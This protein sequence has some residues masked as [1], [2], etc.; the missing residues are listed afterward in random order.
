MNNPFL[1]LPPEGPQVPGI[2]QDA[3]PFLDL[4]EEEV[5]A[6]G[7]FG[8][9]VSQPWQEKFGWNDEQR[10]FLQDLN[11]ISDEHNKYNPGTAVT[12][13]V[14]EAVGAAADIVGRLGNSGVKGISSIIASVANQFGLSETER[15][16]LERDTELIINLGLM[17]SA[18]RPGGIGRNYKGPNRKPEGPGPFQQKANQHRKT[19][20]AFDAEGI[21]PTIPALT[22]SRFVQGATNFLRDIPG[23]A[24]VLERRINKTLDQFVAAKNKAAPRI[25]K[26][27]RDSAG[28]SMRRSIDDFINVKSRD[29]MGD[30]YKGAFATLPE[31][32]NTPIPKTDKGFDLPNLRAALGNVEK[33]R[34]KAG[35][36]G[37]GVQGEVGGALDRIMASPKEKRVGNIT[38]PDALKSLSPAAKERIRKASEL[39]QEVVTTLRENP[40]IGGL[41]DLRTR[42]GQLK[43]L[44]TQAGERTL[45][46]AQVARL[47][48]ALSEDI[49]YHMRNIAG[50]NSVAALRSADDA[51]IQM[52]NLIDDLSRV[53]K[54][55]SDEKI[56]DKVYNMARSGGSADKKA[57]KSILKRMDRPANN[58]FKTAIIQ[59]MGQT[60]P[61]VSDDFSLTTFATNYR[62][63]KAGGAHIL[64]HGNTKMRRSLDRLAIIA[65][66]YDRV[67]KL[68]NHSGTGRANL[69]YGMAGGGALLDPIST[70]TFLLGN[71][72]MSRMLSSQRAARAYVNAIEGF[73]KLG[74]FTKGTRRD[75]QSLIQKYYQDVARL[76]FVMEQD[77]YFAGQAEQFQNS[78]KESFTQSMSNLVGQNYTMGRHM[79]MQTFAAAVMSDIEDPQMTM[80]NKEFVTWLNKSL[81]T[82]K[83]MNNR[84]ILKHME[85][86]RI[87]TKTDPSLKPVLKSLAKMFLGNMED[88]LSEYT[89]SLRQRANTMLKGLG[90]PERIA[91]GFTGADRGFGLLDA[92][93]AGFAFAG[94]EFNR[95]REEGSNLGMLAAGLSAI[96]SPV[97]KVGGKA[98]SKLPMDKVSRMNRAKKQGYADETFYRGE[99]SGNP[100]DEYSGGA[101]FS[102]DPSYADGFAKRGGKDSATKFKL[103]MQNTFS[104]ADPVDAT[105]LARIVDS[106]QEI[107]P[108]F[109]QDLVDTIAPGK[110][111]EW[112]KKFAAHNPDMVVAE[113]GAIIRA[114]VEN[115]R[116][117]EKIFVNAGF[118]SLDVGR[119]VRKLTG[120][121]IRKESANFDPAK[122]SSRNVNH[123][124]P[125]GVGVGGGSALYLDD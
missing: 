70:G 12:S 5:T 61:G 44:K 42:I 110:S 59:R 113:N 77:D 79:D 43:D 75:A 88:R 51:N 103:N 45:D 36:Q 104:D 83:A 81:K 28:A 7:R 97:G 47:Y 82:G 73:A 69:F 78:M 112:F 17:K 24:G 92:T 6:L 124:L 41:R 26:V 60:K 87:M 106:A 53:I 63:L 96:P 56:F 85:R 29:E 94:D 68:A 49:A 9:A 102:R 19:L 23:S 14:V 55:G 33:Q 108:K 66:K 15:K 21:G 122:V 16:D 58:A 35:F 109:A 20:E 107:D 4:P 48:G 119:D 90:I 1:D 71:Y 123:L 111:P 18:Q 13:P 91:Q 98:L 3:N 101:F 8:E 116:A 118:D 120:A 93:P 37:S 125:L 80:E 27:E 95:A 121:G 105:K 84:D 57:L 99:A 40:T 31:G 11:L 34:E 64:F 100:A 10:D 38:N 54:T 32:R 25:T 114:M 65:D 46:Q 76:G 74:R 2:Q 89:P 62:D 30:I 52:R 86:L 22:E 39:E 67:A 72:G 115:S 117:P 50:E